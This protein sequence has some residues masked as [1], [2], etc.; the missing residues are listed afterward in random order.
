MSA[1]TSTQT[2]VPI[3]HYPTIYHHPSTFPHPANC[4]FP[5]SSPIW[6][7][8]GRPLHVR[9]T[10]NARIRTTRNTGLNCTVHA[11]S[12]TA[13]HG[14]CTVHV[15]SCKVHTQSMHSKAQSLDSMSRRNKRISLVLCG[16]VEGQLK[17][18]NKPEQQG[19]K[20]KLSTSISPRPCPH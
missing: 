12:S 3:L 4:H 10:S 6:L 8:F 5:R 15:Q 9:I 7:C 19:W 16:C 18:I 13:L 1:W 2:P 11:Q 17:G 14:P 20:S